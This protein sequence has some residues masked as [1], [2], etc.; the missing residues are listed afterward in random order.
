MLEL[1]DGIRKIDKQITYS[2]GPA[3]IKQQVGQCVAETLLVHERITGKHE[4]T[5]FTTAR[6]WGKPPPS[7]YSILYAWPRD[8]HPNVILSLDS[9]V[10]VLKFPKIKTFATL[11]VHNFVCRPP[12]EV[13]S[14]AKLQFLSRAFQ[15]NVAHHVHVRKSGRFP[16]FSGRESN[17]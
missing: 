2:H 13:R 12:I 4:L 10:K 9:Q 16:T 7:P 3:Q 6:T 14:K 5:R 11:G 8:Q 15:L 17:C 1:Q